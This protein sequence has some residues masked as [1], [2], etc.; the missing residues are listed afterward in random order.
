M[1]GLPYVFVEFIFYSTHL[2]LMSNKLK[3]SWKKFCVNISS[4]FTRR[5]L[6]L[7]S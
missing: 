4:N 5:I 2:F 6:I 7:I 3:E 1:I